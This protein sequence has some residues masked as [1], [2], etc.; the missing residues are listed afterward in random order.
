MREKVESVLNALI[1]TYL[2]LNKPISSTTLKNEAD[3]PYSASTIRS[4]LQT[5]EKNGLAQKEHISSGSKPSVKA[6]VEFWQEVLPGR[7]DEFDIDN[8]KNKCE[9]LDIFAYIKMF[10]NQ[11]LNE[12]YN[13]HNKFIIME[14]EKDEV[15]LRYDENLFNFLY[16]LRGL[17][18]NDIRDIFK[19]YKIENIKKLDNLYEYITINQKIL[20]NVYSEPEKSFFKKL[21]SNDLSDII[22]YEKGALIYKLRSSSFDK[23]IEAVFVADVYSNF[24]D[25]ISSIKGGENG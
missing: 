16:S 4:Y 10:D 2:K 14:F 6:M 25:L 11:M 12:V 22:N 3:L 8:I 23:T 1:Y 17:Y 13:F 20:Y 5:L 18:L 21:E 7:I 15:V 9:E 19:K 24:L